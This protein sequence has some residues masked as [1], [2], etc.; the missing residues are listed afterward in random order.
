MVLYQLTI[1][2]RDATN[3]SW[4][5]IIN[6]ALGGAESTL[7]GI[8]RQK[9]T[10]IEAYAGM[11]ERPVRDLAIAEALQDEIKDTL[12]HNIHSYVDRCDISDKEK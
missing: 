7:A 10:K 2:L 1:G 11:T 6:K 5:E 3:Q 12:E 9:I 8:R 4:G